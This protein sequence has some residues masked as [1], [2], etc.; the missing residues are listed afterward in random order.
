MSLPTA[1]EEIE[2]KDSGRRKGSFINTSPKKLEA[3]KERHARTAVQ[4]RYEPETHELRISLPEKL[5]GSLFGD[6][7]YTLEVL[8]GKLSRIKLNQRD[9]DALAGQLESD[10]QE[11]TAS[12]EST[13]Q[14]MV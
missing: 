8:R 12:P 1:G 13:D 2:L 7:E 11:V 14:E 6:G 10:A 4:V 9:P 3:L 5:D